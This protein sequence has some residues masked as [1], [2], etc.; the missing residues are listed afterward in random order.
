[1]K[2]TSQLLPESSQHNREVSG[3]KPWKGTTATS[4]PGFPISTSSR[5]ANHTP[6]ALAF[7]VQIDIATLGWYRGSLGSFADLFGL[8]LAS[9]L[10]SR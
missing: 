10:L 9:N 5:R 1:M 8:F 3:M 7:Q 6:A 2:G 4:Q